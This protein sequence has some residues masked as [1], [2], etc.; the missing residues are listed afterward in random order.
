MQRGDYIAAGLS[1]GVAILVASTRR[2]SAKASE[3][4]GPGAKEAHLDAATGLLFDSSVVPLPRRR[5][6]IEITPAPA[7]APALPITERVSIDFLTGRELGGPELA[8]IEKEVRDAF[9]RMN[10]YYTETWYPQNIGLT[11]P[12]LP[13][14]LTITS[15]YRSF[16]DQANIVLRMLSS[17]G[18]TPASSDEAVRAALAESLTTRSIPGFSRHHWGT[19]IDVIDP[20][21]AEWKPG[22]RYAPLAAFMLNEAPRFGFYN[23]YQEGGSPEPA[24]P[25]Y[26][27]EPWHLSYFPIADRLHERWLREVNPQTLLE[28]VAQ[29]LGSVASVE[30][31]RR[32][33]PSLD[34]PSYQRNIAPLP[35]RVRQPDVVPRPPRGFD[36]RLAMRVG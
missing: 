6:P 31:L 29:A 22:A 3:P 10:A 2:A 4:A 26:Q 18:I 7:P 32:V 20:T 24:R 36:P 13:P 21:S 11:R 27:P 34:L 5:P 35:L 19:E 25:H 28:E 17:L 14:T 30:A 8:A 23:P 1:L 16:A 33:L 15:Q 9:G 12:D